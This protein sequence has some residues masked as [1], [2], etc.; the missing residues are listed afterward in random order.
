MSEEDFSVDKIN[1]IMSEMQMNASS[2]SEVIK[3]KNKIA[4]ACGWE[5]YQYVGEKNEDDIPHGR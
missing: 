1:E 2:S 3:P 5:D 4:E